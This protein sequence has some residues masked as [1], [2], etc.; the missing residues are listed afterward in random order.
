MCVWGLV[1]GLLGW[2]GCGL[3]LVVAIECDV[4]QGKLTS[5]TERESLGWAGLEDK[6]GS[7]T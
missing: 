7:R 2:T 4:A 3:L 6:S 1:L 5:R